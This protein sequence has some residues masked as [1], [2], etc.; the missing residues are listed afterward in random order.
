MKE[1]A[2]GAFLDMPE[3]QRIATLKLG[4]DAVRRRSVDQLTA[5]LSLG[6]D[7]LSEESVVSKIWAGYNHF[8]RRWATVGG[9][10]LRASRYSCGHGTG[11]RI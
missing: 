5:L 9:C 10:V 4:L 1:T 2:S 8:A 3:D 7:M 6:A 11:T